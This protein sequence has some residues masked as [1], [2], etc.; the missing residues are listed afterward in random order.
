MNVNKALI[1]NTAYLTIL[2]TILFVGW[3]TKNIIV[4]ITNAET[5]MIL[6][7][8]L[9]WYFSYIYL[10][11]TA[12]EKYVVATVIPII[13]YSNVY[14]EIKRK[15]LMVMNIVNDTITDSNNIFL[16]LLRK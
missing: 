11:A 1:G 4:D 14:I 5:D 16:L 9:S 2:K 3:K 15:N 12:N 6:N 10:H 8:F 7:I 13:S